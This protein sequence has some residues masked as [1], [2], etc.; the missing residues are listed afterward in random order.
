MAYVTI[1]SKHLDHFRP[2][3]GCPDF[4][5][6]YS[7]HYTSI[8]SALSLLGTKKQGNIFAK[9][10]NEGMYLKIFPGNLGR[11]ITSGCNNMLFFQK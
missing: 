5:D 2:K 3:L 10:K 8:Q 4:E 6:R 1:N 9:T 11:E 7:G